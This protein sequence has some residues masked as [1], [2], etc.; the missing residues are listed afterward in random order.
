MQTS[1]IK[2]S[3]TEQVLSRVA[4]RKAKIDALT[5][6]TPV[7]RNETP[8]GGKIISRLRVLIPR[9]SAEGLNRRLNWDIR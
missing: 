5:I 4:P 3:R 7:G 9:G 1:R 2:Q 8:H 6:L